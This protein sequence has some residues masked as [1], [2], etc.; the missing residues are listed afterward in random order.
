M[1]IANL[2]GLLH[3]LNCT[4][5]NPNPSNCAAMAKD[6]CRHCSA[7]TASWYVV[8]VEHDVDA[9]LQNIWPFRL[10]MF[11]GDIPKSTT[12][13]MKLGLNEQSNRGGGGLGGG[14]G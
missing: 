2:W 4:Y 14:D 5:H 1:A 9:M 12:C 8:S 3:A 10:A 6:L 13:F 11:C 7:G